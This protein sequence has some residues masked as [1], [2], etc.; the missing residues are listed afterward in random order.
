MKKKKIIPSCVDKKAQNLSKC[1]SWSKNRSEDTNRKSPN[2]NKMLSGCDEFPVDSLNDSKFVCSKV[3]KRGRNVNFFIKVTESQMCKQNVQT[4]IPQPVMVVR[5]RSKGKNR[6]RR[7]QNILS[8]DT[9]SL[10]NVPVGYV[11]SF[12][13]LGTWGVFWDH[14]LCLWAGGGWRG[15]TRGIMQQGTGENHVKA[16][17]RAG[18]GLWGLEGL[19]GHGIWF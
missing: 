4:S 2:K 6:R 14:E 9:W 19:W 5:E 13:N 3:F 17:K 11:L 15:S 10:C 12:P 7:E 1:F 16:L 18:M 8:T